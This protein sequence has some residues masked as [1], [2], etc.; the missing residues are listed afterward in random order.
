MNQDELQHIG[1][2]LT[3]ILSNDNNVRKA[4][5][6]NLVNIKQQ[7]PDKYACYLVAILQQRK[8]LLNSL[9]IF[10]C[11]FAVYRFFYSGVPCGREI[12]G[13]GHPEKKHLLHSVRLVGRW[14]PGEQ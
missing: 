11:E 4:G 6:G 2:I 12:L 7:E 5:E 10:H 8:C 1:L 14:Q 9:T 13:C 3:Q